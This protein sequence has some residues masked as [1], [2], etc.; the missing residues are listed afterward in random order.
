VQSITVACPEKANAT[1]VNESETVQWDNEN[2]RWADPD[3]T[4]IC[5]T[6]NGYH[7]V[8]NECVN[9]YT[10]TFNPVLENVEVNPNEITVTYGT[11]YGTLPTVSKD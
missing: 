5:D 11:A 9:T 2:N 1:P 10:V 3:C 4:Y 6:V 7:E 8:N